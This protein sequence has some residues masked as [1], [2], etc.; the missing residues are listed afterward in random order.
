MGKAVYKW[1]LLGFGSLSILG[2]HQLKGN[3]LFQLSHRALQLLGAY[4]ASLQLGY[5]TP[6]G[7]EAAAHVAWL[8]LNHTQADHL[9]LKL[10]YRNSL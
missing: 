9:I 7:A 3:L 8:Y 1:R 10:D 6:S 2:A 4:L 5:V